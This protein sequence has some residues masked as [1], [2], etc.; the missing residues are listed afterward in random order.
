MGAQQHLLADGRLHL[1]HGPID[2]VIGAD[3]DRQ[4]LADAHTAAWQLFASLLPALV[5]ELA[6]LRSPVV[7]GAPLH[8]NPLRGGVARAM[9]DAC[10]PHRAS[11]ITPMAAVAGAVADAVAACYQREGIARAWVNNGGDIALVLAPGASVRV[12]LVADIARVNLAA[13]AAPGATAATG[14]TGAS[15]DLP[16]DGR[17]DV[18]AALPVRGVATSGWRGRSFS[19]GIADSVTVLASTAA[20]ADACATVVANAVDIDDA[21]IL[22][23]PASALKDDT[24]LGDLPVTCDVPPL[25]FAVV[26]TALAAGLR[27]AETLRARGL[28]WGALLTCQGRVRATGFDGSA[29]L[30]DDDD[31][32]GVGKGRAA[33]AAH[34]GLAFA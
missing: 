28:L 7:P 6:I 27:M 11:F 4:A 29:L 17:F 24:D 12:G 26:D 3:G 34:C 25:G 18:C 31:D 19:L 13:L 32:G 9:W 8:R 2:L 16:L 10:W 21:R 20:L 5:E 30:H 1:Q 23:R 33:A 14:A 22:R 15:G